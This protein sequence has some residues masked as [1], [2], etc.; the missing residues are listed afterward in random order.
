MITRRYTGRSPGGRNCPSIQY[1]KADTLYSGDRTAGKLRQGGSETRSSV[2]YDLSEPA[3]K[4]QRLGPPGG[5][6]QRLFE[7]YQPADWTAGTSFI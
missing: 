7:R 4:V 5:G 3:V 6:S 2:F 1:I